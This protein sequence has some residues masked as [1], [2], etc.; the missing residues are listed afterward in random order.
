MMI[1]MLWL[2]WFVHSVNDYMLTR[3]V[4]SRLMYNSCASL[5]S[6]LKHLSHVY[7]NSW[8]LPGPMKNNK[9][10]VSIPPPF[11]D[12]YQF[13]PSIFNV[14]YS[15]F[16]RYSVMFLISVHVHTLVHPVHIH[17]HNTLI[18]IVKIAILYSVILINLSTIMMLVAIFLSSKSYI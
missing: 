7:Y 9:E 13:S 6:I 11:G 8:L 18:I 15:K 3:C 14:I 4:H 2:A 12:P 17:W 5:H 10:G 16:W 1:V